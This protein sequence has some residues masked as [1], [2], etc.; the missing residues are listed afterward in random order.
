M[1]KTPIPQGLADEAIT[2][3]ASISGGKDSTAMALWLKFESGLKNPL[4]FVCADTGHE[5]PDTVAYLQLLSVILG[6]PIKMVKG[7]FTFLSLAEKKTVFPSTR[8]R[9]CTEELK[10]K[11]LAAYADELIESGIEP[12]F[13]VGVRAEESASRARLEPWDENPKTYECPSWRPMLQWTADEVFAIHK[14]HNVPPNPL[15]L[16][17]AKRVG[18]WPCIMSTKTD[19]AFAFEHDEGLLPRL[20]EYERI[21]GAASKRGTATFFAAD[22]VS[23]GFHDIIWTREDGEVFALASAEAVHRWATDPD[24]PRL[25]FGEPPS[26]MSHYGLCE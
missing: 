6:E 16:Q 24:Q 22:K 11:P 8:A 3:V 18:C 13:A 4:R 1:D 26:C 23:A 12:V 19:L 25:D 7:P 14:R 9:F 15:Y 5:H 17:G 21:V 2:I 20:L 10:I